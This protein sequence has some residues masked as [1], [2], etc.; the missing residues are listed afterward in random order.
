M[1]YLGQYIMIKQLYD[2]EQ[3]HIVRCGDDD[4]GVLLGIQSFSVK[5]PSPLYDM[6]KRN[7]LPASLPD[8]VKTLTV[9]R[10]QNTSIL[11]Q[12]QPQ[13]S[14][15]TDFDPRTD[16]GGSGSQLKRRSPLEDDQA[17][18]PLQPLSKQPRLEL[19]F[20]EWD[21][22]GLPW[23]FLGN[24]K[25]SYDPLSN[26]ST[27]IP[28]NQDIDTAVV[29]DTTDDL[30]FLNEAGSDHCNE[31]MKLETQDSDRGSDE[32][33]A[34]E[35]GKDS[36]KEGLDA[37]FQEDDLEESQC[38]SDDTDIDV[39]PQGRWQCTKCRNF[40]SPIKRY[41]LCCWALRKNWYLDC[42]KL[43]HSL[44]TSDIC[45]K[46]GEKERD[47]GIDIPDCRRTISAPVVRPRDPSPLHERSRLSRDDS[48]L[49]AY[50]SLGVGESQKNLL[51]RSLK[52]GEQQKEE[53]LALIESSKS[54]LEPCQLCQR[55]P[56]NGNII[57]GRTG[58][59]VAC[60][61]CAK[62]LK[63]GGLPCPVCKK[64]IQMVVKTFIA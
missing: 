46:F 23:W 19:V 59:L 11:R 43:A 26:G 7:L 63:R 45:A 8:A 41:C 13:S 3:Q 18:D 28:T 50:S 1:H 5:D 57:H 62:A 60:F 53:D 29:S 44:S 12:D 25:N 40:N 15:G 52:F 61:L 36:G 6:L 35:E 39:T 31:E 9:A 10:D 33:L 24:L 55:K 20:E 22:A 16:G 14:A 32:E 21:V 38:L 2:K 17:E 48:D 47:E 51:N 42:P 37:T 58:H 4:L 64:P 49:P 27:D 30:W 56:R 34:A 54:L